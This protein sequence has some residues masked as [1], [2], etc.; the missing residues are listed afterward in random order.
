MVVDK[1]NGKK[2]VKRMDP[3]QGINSSQYPLFSLY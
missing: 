3:M 1:E 2:E